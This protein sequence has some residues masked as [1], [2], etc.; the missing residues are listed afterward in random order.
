MQ[1]QMIVKYWRA[2]K[3]LSSGDSKESSKFSNDYPKLW[4]A[5]K[6]W[7]DLKNEEQNLM[8]L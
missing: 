5:L 8:V 2:K 1:T 4:R 3:Q 7:F 6:K